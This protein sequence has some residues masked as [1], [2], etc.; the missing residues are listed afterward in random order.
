MTEPAIGEIR[1]AVDAGYKGWARY[2]WHACEDCGITRWVQYNQLLAGRHKRCKTCGSKYIGLNN[3]RENAYNWNGGKH[4]NKQGY[5]LVQ[6]ERDDP[7]RELANKEGYI[8]EHRLIMSRHLNRSLLKSEIVHHKNGIKS[9]NRAENL[10]LTSLGQHTYD[11]SK[12]YKDGYRKGLEEGR[13]RQ[14]QEL[15]KQVKELR[16]EIW[17]LKHESD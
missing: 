2:I 1:K 15:R 9:D 10:E 16:E 12:G 13:T 6:V 8:L 5:V 4:I 3:R 11:H 14:V 7:L 17:R